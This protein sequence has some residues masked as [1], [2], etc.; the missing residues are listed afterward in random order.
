VYI[1]P[2]AQQDEFVAVFNSSY[3]AVTRHASNQCS[4]IQREA[5]FHVKSSSDAR[6]TDDFTMQSLSL[7]SPPAICRI[8]NFSL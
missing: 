2:F 7:K 4:I 1:G 8:N 6:L 3:N 5:A